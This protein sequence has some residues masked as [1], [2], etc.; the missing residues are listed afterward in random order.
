MLA[1]EGLYGLARLL[2][3]TVLLPARAV[4]VEPSG[5][6]AGRILITATL[7]V[8]FFV[9]V[10]P[11]GLSTVR[12]AQMRTDIDV[13]TA[14]SQWLGAQLPSGSHVAIEPYSATLDTS[15]FDVTYLS[16]GLSSEPMQWYSAHDIQYV[17]TSDVTDLRYLGDPTAFPLQ[18]QAYLS[19]FRTWPAVA[20]FTGIDT[21]GAYAGITIRV[22]RVSPAV[23]ADSTSTARDVGAVGAVCPQ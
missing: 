12:L 7:G 22:L 6:R 13:R 19:M 16:C 18:S 1:A 2:S 3:R 5:G 10:T 14:A 15:R 9:G 21:S 8:A 17:V 23:A 20:T 11:L 4:E